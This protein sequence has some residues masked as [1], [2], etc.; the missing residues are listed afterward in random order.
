MCVYVPFGNRFHYAFANQYWVDSIAPTNDELAQSTQEPW[1]NVK[2]QF[3][4]QRFA[5][6]ANA[7]QVVEQ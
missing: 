7:C 4:D 6:K 3:M 1:M 5:M 2:A